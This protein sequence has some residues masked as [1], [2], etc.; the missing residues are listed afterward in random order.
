MSSHDELTG[1]S[2]N[3]VGL[4]DDLVEV[5]LEQTFIGDLSRQHMLAV[6][7]N[8]SQEVMIRGWRHVIS[9]LGEFDRNAE[10]GA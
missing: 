10:Q 8:L 5:D 3:R 1:R 7:M 4:F 9:I 6:G 2:A